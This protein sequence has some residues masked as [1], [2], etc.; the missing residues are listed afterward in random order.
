MRAALRLLSDNP[1]SG[2]IKLLNGTG[3]TLRRLVG[4][5]RI[6]YELDLDR[7]VVEVTAIKTSRI[8]HL[9]VGIRSPPCRSVGGACPLQPA[10]SISTPHRTRARSDKV[11]HIANEPKLMNPS[12]FGLPMSLHWASSFSQ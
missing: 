6:L 5:W 11:D 3:R 1:Y 9:L 2:D 4:N 10:N 7:K 8:E 12:M